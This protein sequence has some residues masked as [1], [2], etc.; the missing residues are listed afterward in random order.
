MGRERLGRLLQNFQP[1]EI[2][3]IDQADRESALVEHYEIIDAVVAEDVEGFGSQL[4]G[5]DRD[6]GLGH[7][8]TYRLN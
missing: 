5:A 8:S 4:V 6:R 7:V 2:L 1:C 3:R